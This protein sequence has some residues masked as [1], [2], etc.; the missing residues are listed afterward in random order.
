MKRK[1]RLS[2]TLQ[3]PEP[4]ALVRTLLA[5][6]RVPSGAPWSV[7]VDHQTRKPT[8]S[9]LTANLGKAQRL[10]GMFEDGSSL[11]FER[12]GLVA[13]QQV[14]IELD[15]PA[16]LRDLGRL[17]FEVAS[18]GAVYDEWFDPALG[19]D[20]PSFSDGHAPLG[21]ACGFRGAGHDR[22]VSRR[23]LEHGPWRTVPQDGDVTWVV[24]HDL[25]AD[26]VVAL[27]QA[28]PGHVRMGISDVGGFIQ[29]A[30]VFTE[31]IKGVYDADT[32][33]LR[34]P[35]AGE[36]VTP[37]KMLEMAAAKRD[38][39]VRAERAIDQVAFVFLRDRD[40]RAQ[41]HDLWLYGLECWAIIDGAEVR[42]DT[43][44]HPPVHRPAWVDAIANR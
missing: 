33:V 44:Y 28:I 35:V 16:T 32:R 15:D 31:D 22:V 9:W 26:P 37:R 12:S 43:D 27:E 7:E 11:L 36:P 18:F 34:V 24:F 29:S 17:P 38:P 10:N 21:W 42:L 20:P 8:A 1:G 25:A 5:A 14:G 23:W 6:G 3:G 40:A 2:V 19:W 4:E 39:R 13:L 41:L 30:F